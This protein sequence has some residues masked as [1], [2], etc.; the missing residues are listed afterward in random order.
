M[1]SLN[2]VAQYNPFKQTKGKVT[3][4]DGKI[5]NYFNAFSDLLYQKH[6]ATDK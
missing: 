4:T 6:L 3:N 2:L 5:Q 1:F